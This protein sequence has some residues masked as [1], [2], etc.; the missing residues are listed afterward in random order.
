MDKSIPIV[1]TPRFL[2]LEN[3]FK[4]VR[5]NQANISLDTATIP[6][7]FVLTV[8]ANQLASI[9]QNQSSRID[10]GIISR[11]EIYGYV[12][13]DLAG[14][15]QLG[16]KSK[17]IRNVVVTLEDGT[18]RSTDNSGK[19]S[20]SNVSPGEH[21]ITLDLES[22]P[23]YYLPKTALTKKITLFE[24]VAYNY[25]IPLKRVEE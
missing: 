13:E 8:P 7:G 19:Y 11:S 23:V 2:Q 10:F 1:Q 25:N 3:G 6:N 15:N 21:Q 14:D 4:K 22:L 17:G 9:S 20:F 18:R 16:K 12:F 5:G 24:G